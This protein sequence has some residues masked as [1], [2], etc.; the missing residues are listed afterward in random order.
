VGERALAELAVY[1]ARPT[2]RV[3]GSE[4]DIVTDLLTAMVMNESEGGLSSLELRFS[5]FASLQSGAAGYAFEDEAVLALGKRIEVYAGDVASPQQ[6]FDG[7][8][9]AIEAEFSQDA[10][11]EMVVLAEDS[12]QSA[13][14]N[15]RTKVYEN[16]S[17][18]QIAEEIASDLGLQPQITS[19]GRRQK[20]HVQWNESDL[21]FL[22]RILA[23][24]DADVQVVGN[25]LHVAPRG[26]VRRGS[27]E[28]RLF[29]QLRAVRFSADLAHQVT[30]TTI[31][32]WDHSSGQ[33]VRATATGSVLGPGSGRTG[34]DVLRNTLGDRGEHVGGVAVSTDAAATAVAAAAFDGRARRF[35]IAEGTT[36]GNP[37]LRVGVHVTLGGISARF[38]NTYYVVRA[39]H[40]YDRRRGY[41]TDF[42]AECAY[43]GGP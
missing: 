13:R 8:V 4:H 9:T 32:G 18:S 26:S 29:G 22:R 28:L 17:T 23:H 15:R 12:L 36:E 37:E 30:Q 35:V 3:E 41:E 24:D 21:A 38:D 27:V 33:R 31:T 34:A 10:P 11:P 7:R 39:T 1:S 42:E 25:E 43:L 20:V 40:R 6:I 5:N 14:M 19:I 16:K 2:L